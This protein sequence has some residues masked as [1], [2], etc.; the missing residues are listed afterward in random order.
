MP[1]FYHSRSF[2]AIGRSLFFYF[3]FSETINDFYQEECDIGSLL[4]KKEKIHDPEFLKFKNKIV[5]LL[6]DKCY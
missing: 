2:L 1:G 6:K 4:Q 5:E 3:R